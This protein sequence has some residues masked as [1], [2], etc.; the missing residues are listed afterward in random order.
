MADRAIKVSKNISAVAEN[1]FPVVKM[2]S[3]VVEGSF[4]DVEVISAVAEVIQRQ[5]DMPKQCAR[6]TILLRYVSS[7]LS[8]IIL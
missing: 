5:R 4:P 2:V 3:A 8:I 6:R 1:T 7:N